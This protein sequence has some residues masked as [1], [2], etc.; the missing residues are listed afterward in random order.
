[1][2]SDH[3]P[4][5][6]VEHP[7]LLGGINCLVRVPQAAIE[8]MRQFLTEEVGSKGTFNRFF[9]LEFDEV[10]MRVYKSVGSPV[11]SF[12]TAWRVFTAMS[13]VMESSVYT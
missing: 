4:D 9:P 6:A 13:N 10:A 8:D 12:T 3:V 5:D 11:L 2:P 1:M 7:Q